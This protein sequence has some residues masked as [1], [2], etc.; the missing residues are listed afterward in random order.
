[1]TSKQP[2]ILLFRPDNKIGDTL[3]E[4]FVPREFKKCY[5]H[6]KLTL[7]TTAPEQLLKNNPHIDRLIVFPPG[8]EGWKQLLPLLFSL[9]KERYD[10]LVCPLNSFKRK[11]FAAI[12]GA[13]RTFDTQTVRY[14]HVSQRFVQMLQAAGVKHVN[15]DYDL[16][17]PSQ[18]EHA[19]SHFLQTVS[20]ENHPFILINPAGS[21]PDRILTPA[22]L[23]TILS[24][25]RQE[26][27]H[28][29][30]FILLDY[31]NQYAGVEFPCVHFNSPH[32]LQVAAL[33]KRAAYVLTMDTSVSRMADMYHKPMT[34][35]FSFCAAAKNHVNKYIHLKNWGSKN[36][37]AEQ[38]WSNGTV[39]DIS[40]ETVVCSVT[41]RLIP[42]RRC[43]Q[44]NPLI[45][46]IVPV[47]NSAKYLTQCIESILAQ[48][49]TNLQIILVDD[50]SADHSGQ[51]CDDY[52]T[53]DCRIKVIHQANKGV[54]AARNAGL[55][56][57][58]GEYIGF[59]DADDYLAPD[60]YEKLM[61]CIRQ[62]NALIAGCNFY[63]VNRQ[64]QTIGFSGIANGPYSVLQTLD[65]FRTHQVIWNKLFHVSVLRTI[66][67]DETSSFGEDML[68]FFFALLQAQSMSYT[69]QPLY[70]YR[71]HPQSVSQL[72]RWNPKHMGYFAATD[73]MIEYAISQQAALPVQQLGLSQFLFAVAFLRRI[74]QTI[75]LDKINARHLQQRLRRTLP[76]WLFTGQIPLVK[77]LF[78]LAV[79]VHI[80]LVHKI[81]SDRKGKRKTP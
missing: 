78:A 71:E 77:K 51:I 75:P 16:F 55:R 65:I 40:V 33:V 19:V 48:T 63:L 3:V 38:L 24:A 44:V 43:T 60:M 54:S 23:E 80:P 8:R 32:I 14:E 5:P 70:Y 34:V 68:F 42:A 22:R 50:G 26:I 28:V 58:Q 64:A 31:K 12:L 1:M 46:V 7:I 66:R 20:L 67:F 72:T 15:T 13:R 81:T 69:A 53:K 17:I 11:L 52:A 73:E 29:Y 35:L 57:A 25:L 10:L 21:H 9:R 61:S 59:V 41:N 30:Q 37:T 18:E 56:A 74:F 47:Y 2:K 4:S 39:N 62:Y 79:C 27:G 49:Y 45:S 36:E 6:G 76:S